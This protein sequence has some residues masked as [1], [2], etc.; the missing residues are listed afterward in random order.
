MGFVQA[1]WLKSSKNW[2]RIGTPPAKTQWTLG[3]LGY[4]GGRGTRTGDGYWDDGFRRNSQKSCRWF[5][6]M[7]ADKPKSHSRLCHTCRGDSYTD[8]I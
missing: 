2:D 5:T 7:D 3:S 1:V 6:Q 4:V 8:F